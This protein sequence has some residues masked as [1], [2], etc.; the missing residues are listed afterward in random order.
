MSF[1]MM[2]MLSVLGSSWMPLVAIEL[3]KYCQ[4]D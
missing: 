4:P 2:E 1:V 3:L